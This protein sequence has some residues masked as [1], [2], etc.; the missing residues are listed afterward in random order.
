MKFLMTLIALFFWGNSSAQMGENHNKKSDCKHGQNSIESCEVYKAKVVKN[1]RMS[2]D[3]E[4]IYCKQKNNTYGIYVRAGDTSVIP[5]PPKSAND[6]RLDH[7]KTIP[8]HKNKQ[9]HI[10]NYDDRSIRK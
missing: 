3:K 2:A 5:I 4:K 10:Y 9:Q 6:S 1:C 8:N 7:I